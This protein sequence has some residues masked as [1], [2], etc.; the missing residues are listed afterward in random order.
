MIQATTGR[1]TPEEYGGHNC[2]ISRNTGRSGCV[3]MDTR[4]TG[5]EG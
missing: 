1:D 5:M 2:R 3:K 4:V